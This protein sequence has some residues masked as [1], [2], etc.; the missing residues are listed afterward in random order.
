MLDSYLD[1]SMFSNPMEKPK[2]ANI[3]HILWQSKIKM[4]RTQKAQMVCDGSSHQGT[5]TLGHTCAN[6]LDAASERLFWAIVALKRLLACGADC[7]NACAEA[8]P[9]KFPLYML[10]DED[11]QDWWENHLM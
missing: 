8:L 6:S 5:I 1:Q 4:Y 10:I 9:P 11:F 3:H 2:G 7:S